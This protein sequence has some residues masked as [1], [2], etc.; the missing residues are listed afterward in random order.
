MN[1]LKFK[2][3]IF[4]DIKIKKKLIKDF[5]VFERIK[6][7]ILS[8]LNR[9]GKIFICG[10][11]GSAAH[12]QHLAAEFMIRLRPEINRRPYPVIS[13]ALDTSTLTACS[14]DYGYN[15]IFS[16]PLEAL[17][18]DKDILII[19][20]T[21]G[22]SK[23][24]IEVLKLAKKKKIFSIGFLGKDGGQAKFLCDF[25]YIVPS[26]SVP[27]IQEIHMFLGHLIFETVEDELMN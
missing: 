24:I 17:G 6:G 21:S 7:E 25:I 8:C 9:S 1:I 2:K 18:C 4:E 19:L 26:K 20:S 14:N 23:N 5:K 27:I 3:K 12:A 11:G 13:L 15:K 22:K 10:N 16:R